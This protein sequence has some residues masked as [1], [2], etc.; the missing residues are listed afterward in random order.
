MDIGSYAS[1]YAGIVSK[2]QK[3]GAYMVAHYDRKVKVETF[4][5]PFLYKLISTHSDGGSG[6]TAS[7]PSS[8]FFASQ[9]SC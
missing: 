9:A 2:R 4:L 1:R 8:S 6:S 3:E 7:L 5:V